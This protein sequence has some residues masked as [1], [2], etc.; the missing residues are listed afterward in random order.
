MPYLMTL[1]GYTPSVRV[2]DVWTQA[3]FEYSASR[4]GPWTLISTETLSPADTDPLL[5]ATR[6]FDVTVPDLGY[7]GWLRVVFLDAL[8]NQ[9]PTEPIYV[10]SAIRPAVLEV[11]NLMPDRT[12]DAD[13]N[14]VGTF[15]ATTRPTAAQ[16]ESLIDLSLD[17]I[18]PDVLSDATT[19]SQRAARSIVALSAAILVEASYFADQGGVNEARIA[20]WERLI[21]RHTAAAGIDA[22]GGSAGQE[23]RDG[24]A[25]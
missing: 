19:E 16:V 3:R 24:V 17:A 14:L 4:S 20:V 6:S 2:T 10:G 12:T 23:L 15:D 21:A 1:T 18:D 7:P 5:P 22:G 11:A 25:I 8:G 13:G 9:E